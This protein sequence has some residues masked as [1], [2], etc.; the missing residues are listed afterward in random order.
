MVSLS[1]IK[2]CYFYFNIFLGEKLFLKKVFL[3]ILAAAN[4]RKKYQIATKYE[5]V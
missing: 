2:I 5:Q 1:F 4:F 3:P